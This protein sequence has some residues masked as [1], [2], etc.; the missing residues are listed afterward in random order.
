[1][2]EYQLDVILKDAGKEAFANSYKIALRE[3]FVN[4]KEPKEHGF[5]NHVEGF[6][7]QLKF[8]AQTLTKLSLAKW[9][10][11]VVSFG[12]NTGSEVNGDRPSI[13]YKETHNTL[14]EDVT[15]IPLTSAVREK[16]ADKFDVSVPKDNDNKLFQNSYARLRQLKAVSIKKI[17]RPLGKITDE[18]VKAAIDAGIKNMLWLQ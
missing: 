11:F 7:T 5:K 1:M 16:L 15:V 18:K 14:W 12:M 13:I 3:T 4:N 8:N 17:G 2:R 10:I 9:Q 6:V